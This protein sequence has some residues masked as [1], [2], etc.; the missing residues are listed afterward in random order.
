MC[1]A[2]T[3][4]ASTPNNVDNAKDPMLESLVSGVRDLFPQLGEGF[5]VQ[6]LPYFD[7]NPEKVINALLE[8]NL[9]P[10]LAELDR[11]LTLKKPSPVPEKK[12]DE[13]QGEK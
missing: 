6:C 3:A 1:T 4:N 2:A 9:P 8:D 5:L 7:N 11:T 12:S 10:H 13:I